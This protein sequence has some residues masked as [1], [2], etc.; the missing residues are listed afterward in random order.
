[1]TLLIGHRGASAC[2][3][4]N[5]L[6]SFLKAVELG[7][8]AVE[9]DVHLSQDGVPVV[10]HDDTVNRTTD[11]KGRVENLTLAQLQLL[12]AGSGECIPT[13]QEVLDALR[14]KV[15]H[16]FIEI[17]DKALAVPV[18]RLIAE[19]ITRGWDY[20][21]LPVICFNPETLEDVREANANIPLG[22]HLDPAPETQRQ[23]GVAKCRAESCLTDAEIALW[24]H[25]PKYLLPNID[26]MPE[27]I[28][29][30]AHR[31]HAQVVAWTIRTKEQAD[32]A[33]TLQVDM[34]IT[35]DPGLFG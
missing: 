5:T 12:D 4:E 6:A 34:A 11:G 32:R 13:L 7:C 25:K 3:P 20:A 29:P 18:A 24:R 33:V 10:I 31:Y 22:V 26:T 17:K 28:V 2:V 15:R 27:G 30:L 1:M 16:V 23:P 19:N 8:D 14:G 21:M 35:D 9:M